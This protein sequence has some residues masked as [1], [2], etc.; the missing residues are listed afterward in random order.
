MAHAT[1]LVPYRVGFIYMISIIF[2]TILVSPDDPRLLGG[3]SVA[4]SPFIIAVNNAGI[5]GI[6]SLLN[7]GMMIGVLAIAAEAV[8]I[9]ARVLRTMSHQK[10]IP[11][12][13]A[14][15]DDK[16]RPRWGL[17]I[18]CFISVLLGYIQLTGRC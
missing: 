5:A 8:Y 17:Y 11:E 18:T 2:V 15:V 13:F 7:A 1:K 12:Y 10:L 4:S 3:S 16:G 9:A 6:P 14:R